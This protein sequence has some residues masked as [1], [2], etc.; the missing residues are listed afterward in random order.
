MKK[1]N[2]FNSSKL[3]IGV[4]LASAII[5]YI[6]LYFLVQN[7]F[8]CNQKGTGELDFDRLFGCIMLII[9]FTLLYL[10]S[11]IGLLIIFMKKRFLNNKG[12]TFCIILFILIIIYIL[13][14]EKNIF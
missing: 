13:C 6:L 5:V 10:L 12:T 3:T 11:I 9:R 14:T 1:T 8:S 2:F 4:I 7:L